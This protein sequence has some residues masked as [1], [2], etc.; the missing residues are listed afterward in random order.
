LNAIAPKQANQKQQENAYL[1]KRVP[2]FHRDK[3]V[4][5]TFLLNDNV[6]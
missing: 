4:I 3:L 6:L 1:S 5:V 2:P